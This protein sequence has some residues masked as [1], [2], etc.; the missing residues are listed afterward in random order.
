MQLVVIHS[1]LS[2]R[3]P[4]LQHHVHYSALSKAVLLSH[5]LNPGHFQ[6]MRKIV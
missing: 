3:V 1:K 2:Q 4:G 5:T 6:D